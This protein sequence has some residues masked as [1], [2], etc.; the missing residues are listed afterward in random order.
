MI[1]NVN[2]YLP[3]CWSLNHP[4]NIIT[5]GAAH[6]WA[7]QNTRVITHLLITSEGIRTWC[8]L[9]CNIAERYAWHLLA[10]IKEPIF[11]WPGC[12]KCK[13]V[14]IF[15]P[16]KNVIIRVL[17]WYPCPPIT[18]QDSS[19]QPIWA[20]T[21]DIPGPGPEMFVTALWPVL[22]LQG[23]AIQILHSDII[24]A[25][26]N[27][28]AWQT[29]TGPLSSGSWGIWCHTGD[30]WPPSCAGRGGANKIW[31]DQN[32]QDYLWPYFTKNVI[33][34]SFCH[35]KCQCFICP[36]LRSRYLCSN[37]AQNHPLQRTSE[38]PMSHCVESKK[39]IEKGGGRFS[40]PVNSFLAF[41]IQGFRP[42]VWGHWRCWQ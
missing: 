28:P 16:G 7:R 14:M 26:H 35:D 1:P 20:L 11:E 2:Q 19:S 42:T 3:E 24:C 41:S 8:L 39:W 25:L 31:V 34:L 6:N 18:S 22:T 9:W 38:Q 29:I 4:D 5:W 36:A 33:R 27:D 23:S 17:H 15:N 37:P 13:H 30:H 40:D 21:L 10:R 12:D 32:H